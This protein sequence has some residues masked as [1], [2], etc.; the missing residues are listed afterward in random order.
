MKSASP[1]PCVVAI[2]PPTSTRAEGLKYTPDGLVRM[3]WPLAVMRPKIWLGS[4]PCTRFSVTLLAPGCW[5]CTCAPLPTLKLCQLIAARS[6]PWVMTMLAPLCAMPAWPELTWPPVGNW[7]AAGAAGATD[8]AGGAARACPACSSRPP[9]RAATTNVRCTPPPG[10][11]RLVTFSAAA[12]KACLQWFQTLR[13]FLFMV[14][15]G[16]RF[17]VRG[18]W[19]WA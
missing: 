14:Q 18:V 16:R 11:P 10:R 1:M 5:N 4:L 19:R 7:P 15:V 8:G 3:T 17:G 2:R 12:T 13:K 9:S 6:L